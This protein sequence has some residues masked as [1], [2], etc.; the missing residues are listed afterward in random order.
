MGEAGGRNKE[1]EPSRDLRRGLD[2]ALEGVGGSL[3]I[4]ALTGTGFGEDNR[5]FR[6]VR[7]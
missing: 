4:A 7:H 1:E 6:D 5:L 2:A 3:C